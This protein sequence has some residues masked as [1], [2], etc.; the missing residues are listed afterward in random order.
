MIVDPELHRTLHASSIQ[1]I[2]TNEIYLSISRGII[3]DFG[4]LSTHAAV[5]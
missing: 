2:H 1:V 5:A 4:Y 3:R